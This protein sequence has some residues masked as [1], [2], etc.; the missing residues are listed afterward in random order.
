[1]FESY[2]GVWQVFV[3]QSLVTRF[4]A[5]TIIIFLLAFFG[6][7]TPKIK[8][9]AAAARREKLQDS[10]LGIVVGGINAYLIIGSI[11]AYMAQAGYDKFAVVSAPIA[12]TPMGDAAIRL[13]SAMPPN[14]LDIPMIYFVI[15][16]AFTFVVVV[17]V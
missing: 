13:V 4:W 8:P 10:L 5:R 3:A 6:Y 7:Q 9:F 1:V 12:G 2:V 11:W 17:Y 16:F 14:Y 15:V